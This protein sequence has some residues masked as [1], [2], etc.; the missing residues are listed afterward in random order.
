MFLKNQ[1]IKRF[2][3]AAMA[4][5]IAAGSAAVQ[6]GKTG[7][8]K[9]E[10]GKTSADVKYKCL[11]NHE[12]AIFCTFTKDKS[13]QESGPEYLASFIE[14]LEGTDVD[15]VMFCPT[16]W[17]ANIFPSE[18]DPWWKDYR[19]GQVTE[20]WRGYDYIMKYLHDGGDPV[21]ETLAACR[22]NEIDFLISYRMN[23]AHY[24]VDKD[25]PTHT[26]FWRDNP[27]Y[28]L[29]D[30]NI[31]ATFKTEEDNVRLHNYM[32]KPVRDWY[33][34]I[35]EE[36]CTNYDIDGIELDFQ[37]APRFFYNRET[38]AGK[39]VM[40][41]FVK[42]IRDMIDRIGTQRGKSL[43]LCVRVPETLAKCDKAGLDVIE[44]DRLKLVEMINISPYYLQSLEVDIE[45]YKTNTAHAKIY[46]E[47]P[48]HTQAIVAPK[49]SD[50]LRY[51]NIQ[52][53]RGTALNFLARGADGVSLFNYDY[54][55]HG[56]PSLAEKR[57][58]ESKL[59]K[60]IT[61]IEFLRTAEKL[62]IIS[63]LRDSRLMVERNKTVK[64]ETTVD[65]VIP[66]DTSKKKFTRCV[67]RVETKD[68]CQDIDISA[69]LNA[70]LLEECEFEKT[71]FF[72]PVVETGHGYPPA[73]KLKFYAVPLS[74]ITAGKNTFRI[75]NLD[76]ETESC[77]IV[78]LE[79]ALYR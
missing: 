43:K 79:L 11:F 45:D 30:S 2:N 34:S 69:R 39:K 62:Y 35:L 57:S 48:R 3:L 4:V 60:D 16:A 13:P 37:R 38:E 66:D 50:G 75:L 70:E 25:W 42:R 19:E 44:W 67:L 72:E 68:N 15:A 23:D 28:W 22:K 29:G 52:T 9:D 7:T 6:A 55:P 65:A 64:N 46:A 77:E 51:A 26:D 73:E 14:K 59:L 8:P 20:K 61:N 1:F 21:A 10:S 5:I 41:G 71:E 18:I 32:L 47:M 58:Q 49:Y 63:P 24:I 78:S 76:K 36:L 54:I 40:T 27:Q 33:F 12:S 17:R 74:D 31:S 56:S 53:Y